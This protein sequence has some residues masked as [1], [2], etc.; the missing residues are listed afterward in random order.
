MEPKNLL[1]EFNVLCEGY[2]VIVTKVNPENNEIEK[3][4]KEKFFD[5]INSSYIEYDNY[6][7]EFINEDNIHIKIIDMNDF[8]IIIEYYSSDRI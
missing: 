8:N 6:L 7:N 1:E 4:I 3:V 2:G 5:N